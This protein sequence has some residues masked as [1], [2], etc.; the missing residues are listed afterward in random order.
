MMQ[1]STANEFINNTS[2]I[3]S[4]YTSSNPFVTTI[5]DFHPLKA[6]YLAVDIPISSTSS[7]DKKGLLKRI[8][9]NPGQDYISN[10]SIK[11]K[12]NVTGNHE[13]SSIKFQIC[14][15]HGV[16]IDLKQRN[17]SGTLVVQQ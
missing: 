7:S 16:V 14:D 5:T 13:I 3:T 4:G 15:I 17:W 6:L 9:L 10:D 8:V 2:L 12:V 11:H 1:F